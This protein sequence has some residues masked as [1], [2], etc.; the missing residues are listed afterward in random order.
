MQ[1]LIEKIEER[2]ED[3][4]AMADFLA[5]RNDNDCEYYSGKESAY[6]DCLE[7]LRIWEKNNVDSVLL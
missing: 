1:D 7:L 5:G 6:Y 4:R 3:A 2:L